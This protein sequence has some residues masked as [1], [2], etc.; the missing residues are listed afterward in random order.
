[1]Q[2]A[3]NQL[4]E[5]QKAQAELTTTIV[6][7][8]RLST[9]VGADTIFVIS[10]GKLAE[11]GT[12]KELIEHGGLYKLL[13]S[14]Q[15]GETR[16]SAVGP[17][18]GAAPAVR[19]PTDGGAAVEPPAGASKAAKSGR[20]K[21]VPSSVAPTE[22][23][24]AAAKKRRK[25]LEAEA[26][27]KA[28]D[29]AK[30][31]IWA[32][33][34]GDRLYLIAGFFGAVANG[35][36]FPVMAVTFAGMLFMLL[37]RSASFM[38]QQSYVLASMFGAIAVLL[39]VPSAALQFYGFGKSGERLTT[40]IRAMV[41]E[42][43]LRTE[44]GFFDLPENGAGEVT[45]RVGQAAASV[46]A[47]TGETLGRNVSMGCMMLFGPFLAMAYSYH[48]V[49]ALF[50]VMPFLMAG[51]VVFLAI[52]QGQ[53]GKDASESHSSLNV[54]QEALTNV[55]TV[56]AMQLEAKLLERY[57]AEGAK[58]VSRFRQGLIP[59]SLIF[60]GSQGLQFLSWSF[61]F[62]YAALAQADAYAT[63]V[64]IFIW[65]G[66]AAGMFV[67][68]AV[69]ALVK[70]KGNDK[71]E[72]PLKVL[73]PLLGMCATGITIGLTV[74]R[75][76]GPNFAPPNFYEV[77]FG[78]FVSVFSTF[79]MA[80]AQIGMTDRE[81]AARAVVSTFTFLDRATVID[82]MDEEG[83]VKPKGLM[84][85]IECIDIDFAYP[86]RPDVLVARQFNLSVAAGETVALVGQSGCGKSTTV[87]LLERFYDPQ[88]G[89]I[90]LDGHDLKTLNVRHLRRSIGLVGQEPVLF[91]GSI[92]SNIARGLHGETPTTAQVEEAARLAN[93]HTFID[94]LD[95][96]YQTNVGERGGQLS[97][98]QKQRIAIARAIIAK[99][100]VLLLDEATSALDNESEKVVQAALDELLAAQKR[101][102][103]VIAH[104]LST[105][106]NADRICFIAGGQVAEQGTHEALLNRQHLY[107]EMVASAQRP[108]DA[109][110]LKVVDLSA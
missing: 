74:A 89:K 53:F 36:V 39:C 95:Q 32:M 85:A 34:K 1:V 2:A 44:I 38:R 8:H 76:A 91:S 48:L 105:I 69:T 19:P 9:I 101:T 97:G 67:L 6:I 52:M 57:S 58:A 51:Q 108:Q 5:K 73:P 23:D 68:T 43:T 21:V 81:E 16:P 65:A 24:E 63:G 94:T 27:I 42:K 109:S 106:R 71:I 20:V 78:L 4:L 25:K 100:I 50:F 98:G 99:P 22:A 75:V 18:A 104:R 103:I 77:I 10:N 59:F 3:L 93:A 55:R 62:W 11:S 92:F 64:F 88:S 13:S 54:L 83:G 45:L 41:F 79:G 90:T 82:G 15:G 84:G 17:P 31:R 102:T 40:K 7:A 72:G 33:Q 29:K 30:G 26:F 37:N 14:K 61:L 86:T 80:N 110:S 28:A 49:L 35:L 66:I 12:H 87:M 56:A 60:A 107:A 47:L 46:K 96:G 70:P